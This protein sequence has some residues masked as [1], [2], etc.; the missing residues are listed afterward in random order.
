M[1]LR[2]AAAATAG[3][4]SKDAYHHPSSHDLAE[5]VVDR[6][7]PTG[8]SAG[9]VLEQLATTRH[10]VGHPGGIP[11]HERLPQQPPRQPGD[12][13]TDPNRARSDRTKPREHTHKLAPYRREA[14]GT[15]HA[16]TR[17]RH[18]FTIEIHAV[19][20]AR[21]VELQSIS[22]LGWTGVPS[23]D[24]RYDFEVP[25]RM[26]ATRSLSCLAERDLPN[27]VG[28]IPLL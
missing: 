14:K 23:P 1:R 11:G 7:L 16:C 4:Q 13:T 20:D 24:A 27:V 2:H 18:T 22:T 15:R 17:S 19:D 3:R 28:M 9:R 6:R 26:K 21:P 5:V 8:P 10:R 12:P 25:E